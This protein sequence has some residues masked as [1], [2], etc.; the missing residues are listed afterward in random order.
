[1][2]KNKLLDTFTDKTESLSDILTKNKSQ[3]MRN[4][5]VTMENHMS[6]GS[7]C[8]CYPSVQ[9]ELSVTEDSDIQDGDMITDFDI[10][11]KYEISH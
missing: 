7:D 8:S 3:K 4:V 11:E 2:F 10:I 9:Y 6:C 1:M 5:S